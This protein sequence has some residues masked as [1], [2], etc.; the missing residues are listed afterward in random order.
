MTDRIVCVRREHGG[1][2][3]WQDRHARAFSKPTHPDMEHV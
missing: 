2:P 3:E 1:R